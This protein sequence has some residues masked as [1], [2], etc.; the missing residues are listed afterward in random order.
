MKRTVGCCF[1]FS[2]AHQVKKL[3]KELSDVVLFSVL[4]IKSKSCD[5][6]CRMLF[7]F[8]Y[9]ASS[10]KAVIRTVGCCFIF[11]T[12]HQVKKLWK[13]LSDVVLFSVLRI[14]SK[15]CDK[16]C[17]M[18]FYFQYCASSQKAVI[19]TV[20]C[21]FIFST[22]H[23]VKKLWKELSDVVLFSVLR[24]KSKSC[25][26]NCRML[27]YFQY[28]ASSQKAVI[29]TV[30]CCFIFSTAHQVKKLW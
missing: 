10:Q 18:L 11:S 3:W 14:K 17:R 13:E 26:K 21:C 12:A 6:N 5:K 28:C 23:Q 24:I 30:G 19:R 7:Y 27:F 9:C 25:D 29:R 16:N 8:Q 15:S 4:R 22:A 1:I 2:T 20:G